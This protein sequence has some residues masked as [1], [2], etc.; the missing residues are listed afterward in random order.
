MIL[1][2]MKVCILTSP[3]FY[4]IARHDIT[5]DTN[6]RTHSILIDNVTFEDFSFAFG[7]FFLPQNSV[8]LMHLRPKA[9]RQF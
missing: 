6:G 2:V 9:K 3:R 5:L 8:D 1:V 4:Y 7:C